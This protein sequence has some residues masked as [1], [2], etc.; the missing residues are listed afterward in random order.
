MGKLGENAGTKE[1]LN[2][3]KIYNSFLRKKVK[4]AV[5]YK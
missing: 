2:I 4:N 5:I 3:D 1:K